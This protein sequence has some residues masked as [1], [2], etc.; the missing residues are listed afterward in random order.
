MSLRYKVESPEEIY[1]VD[2]WENAP[3]RSN[4]GDHVLGM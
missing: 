4:R 2:N 1:L 3:G